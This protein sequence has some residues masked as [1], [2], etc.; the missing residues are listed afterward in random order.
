MGFDH[1]KHLT[2]LQLKGGG[3][4]HLE[5]PKDIG[6]LWDAGSLQCNVAHRSMQSNIYDSGATVSSPH[7]TAYSATE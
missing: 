6:L 3:A 4:I 2:V 1:L 5:V 7:Q